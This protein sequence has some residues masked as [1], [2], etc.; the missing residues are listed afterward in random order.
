VWATGTLEGHTV[1]VQI[2]DPSSWGTS[3]GGYH[4]F[5]GE[6][7]SSTDQNTPTSW[8]VQSPMGISAF[9]VKSG[10][11]FDVTLQPY[12]AGAYSPAIARTSTLIVKGTVVC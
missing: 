9:N 7:V 10:A 3:E 11:T 5:V 4:V 6:E 2:Y 1:H 12:P 8:A